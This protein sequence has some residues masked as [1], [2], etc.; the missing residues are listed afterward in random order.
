MRQTNMAQAQAQTQTIDTEIQ[1]AAVDLFK[2]GADAL[3]NTVNC[4]GAM[5]AGL[6]K[7][8]AQRYPGMLP[9]YQAACRQGKLRPGQLHLWRNPAARDNNYKSNDE[10]R[11]VINFPT[12][13]DWRDDSKLEYIESG[14]QALVQAVQQHGITSLA[15]PPLGCGL[16]GLDLHVVKPLML[17]ALQPLANQGVKITITVPR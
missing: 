2:T 8:F 13:D 5:G 17:A 11:W 3:V 16:G 9:S 10:P 4:K 1:V 12:K 15:V 14:L 6:A 7:Q